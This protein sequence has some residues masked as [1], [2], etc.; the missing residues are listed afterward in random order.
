[1]SLFNGAKGVVC[2]FNMILSERCLVTLQSQDCGSG[3]W[4]TVN[5]VF[6]AGITDVCDDQVVD[7]CAIAWMRISDLCWP[8]VKDMACP[9]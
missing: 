1:V 8:K 7:G 9:W 5:N 4:W 2:A 3:I 6:L